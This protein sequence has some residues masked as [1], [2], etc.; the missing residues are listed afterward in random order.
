MSAV[1]RKNRFGWI[2]YHAKPRS[3][4]EWERVFA[5]HAYLLPS[6]AQLKVRLSRRGAS[7]AGLRRFRFD[8]LPAV[9]HHNALSA[10]LETL[11]EEASV[12]QLHVVMRD[13]TTHELDCRGLREAAI[14]DALYALDP[15]SN[16]QPYQPEADLL[17][18]EKAT[19]S[20]KD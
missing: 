10:S 18:R 17:L 16:R 5:R 6:V 14:L 19:A 4:A 13:G 11:T 1:S 15:A 3:P 7:L 12:A 2:K 8:V 20:N 9:E